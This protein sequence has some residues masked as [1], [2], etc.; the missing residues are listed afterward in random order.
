MP[1]ADSEGRTIG[2]TATFPFHL[3]QTG[4]FLDLGGTDRYLRRP[5]AGGDD[6]PDA[7]AGDGKSWSFTAPRPEGAGPNVARGV[8]V[9]SGRVGFLAPFPRRR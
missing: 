6:A 5:A 4:L 3:P 9:P 7:N 2:R 1:A 8:D